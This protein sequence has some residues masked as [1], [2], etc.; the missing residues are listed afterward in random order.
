MK[1]AK[2]IFLYKKYASDTFAGYHTLLATKLY[3]SKDKGEGIILVRNLM[4][5]NRFDSI[6][7]NKHLF[8]NDQLETSKRFSKLRTVFDLINEKMYEKIFGFER[9]RF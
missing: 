7:Q 6:K 5:R 8:E 3:G 1:F 2:N 9:P 4:S